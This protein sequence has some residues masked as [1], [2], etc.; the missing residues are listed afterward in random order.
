MLKVVVFY[1]LKGFK[2]RLGLFVFWCVFGDMLSVCMV[3]REVRFVWMCL[4]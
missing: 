1:V 2:L 3:L 4:R